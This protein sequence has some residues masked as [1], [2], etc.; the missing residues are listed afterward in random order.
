MNDD[1]AVGDIVELRGK[2]YLT[3]GGLARYYPESKVLDRL[4]KHMHANPNLPT[5][6]RP[7]RDDPWLLVARL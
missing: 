5:E 7:L 2:S 1:E 4:V 3:A 6:Y